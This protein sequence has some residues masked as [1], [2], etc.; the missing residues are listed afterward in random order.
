[1]VLGAGDVVDAGVA[2]GALAAGVAGEAGTAGVDGAAW[3]AGV[4]VVDTDAAAAACFL[5]WP[6]GTFAVVATVEATSL[7]AFLIWPGAVEF[8]LAPVVD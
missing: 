6:G 4:T 1:M 3:L 2:A 5:A 7:A 8:P